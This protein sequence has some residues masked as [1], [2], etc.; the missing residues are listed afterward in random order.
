MTHPRLLR[1]Y[2]TRSVN[3]FAG[4]T[5]WQAARATTA[6][7]TFFK[8]VWIGPPK[9]EEAFIDGGV[10]TN[11]PVRLVIEEAARVFGQDRPV[12]C[13][14][15]LGTGQGNTIGFN[16][17]GWSQSW[18]PTDLIHALEKMATDT[19]RVEQEMEVRFANAPGVYHRFNVDQGLQ[20]IGMEEWKRL[21]DVKT[22][23]ILYLNQHAVE[24]RLKGAAERLGRR[25]TITTPAIYTTAELGTF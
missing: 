14:V 18:V 22:H 24:T 10:G 25:D 4:T 7:P 15:S 23:T 9:L 20:N 3:Q 12:S 1:S 17:P 19:E 2:D 8:R 21:G 5:I 16:T 6:A 11:N 13:V